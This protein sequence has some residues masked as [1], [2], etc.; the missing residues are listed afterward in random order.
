MS[1]ADTKRKLL[2][3]DEDGKITEFFI[4]PLK[5]PRRALLITPET[6]EKNRQIWN[7]KLEKAEEIW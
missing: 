3:K 4:I 1:L 7:D 2:L 6:E 5:D